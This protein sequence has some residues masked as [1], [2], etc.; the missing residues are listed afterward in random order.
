MGS[1]KVNKNSLRRPVL[2]IKHF[3]HFTQ[4]LL[5]TIKSFSMCTEIS[6]KLHVSL[7]YLE[8][9]SKNASNL[10]LGSFATGNHQLSD[11]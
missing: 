9:K 8:T 7:L 5:M 3:G 11:F 10:K 6:L 4:A 2:L 1:S